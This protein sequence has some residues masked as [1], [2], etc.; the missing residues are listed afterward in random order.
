MVET[1]RTVAAVLDQQCPEAVETYI[2]SGASEAAHLLEVLLLA[3]EA[4]LFRPADGVSRL[5]IVPLFETL[6]SLRSA[7]AD[8]PA[9]ADAA[10]LPAAPAA[11]RR[12]AGGH[13]RLLRQQQG[14]RLRCNRR[15]RCTGRRRRWQTWAGA[16]A[17]RCR[18]S[19]AAAAPSAAAAVPANRAILAQPRGTVD[20][21]LRITEQGEMIADRYGHHAIAERH[22]GQVLNAVCG[23]VSRPTTTGRSRV[24]NTSS[25]GWPSALPALPRAGVR[26]AGVPD[27][28]RAGDAAGGSVAAE[29]RL[30]AVA[31]RR[32]GRHRRA[33]G[34]PVGVQLDAEPAHAAGLVRP[35]RRGRRAPGRASRRPGPAAGHVPALAVLDAP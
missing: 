7:A 31:A 6:E 17:S 1:F 34:D 22:L 16:R 9:A 2:I 15:G 29:D 35:R 19:T 13:D 10:G 11:A 23:A 14:E 21:R 30:A 5:H 28:F 3:R 8:P 18:S 27:L 33:A 24:G 12:R 4:R 32:G 20:G 26:D 25:T